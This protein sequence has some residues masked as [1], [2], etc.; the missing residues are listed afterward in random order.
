MARGASQRH[1][2]G[3]AEWSAQAIGVIPVPSIRHWQLTSAL[4]IALSVLL[5]LAVAKV[6]WL[7]A[8]DT[9]ISENL[10][11]LDAGWLHSA[12]VGVSAVFSPTGSVAII[13]LAALGLGLRRRWRALA[14]TLMTIGVG[15]LSSMVVKI[16]ID[17]PRPPF[18]V[19][20]SASFPS[21]HVALTT[22]V[23][24]AVFFLARDIDVRDTVAVG[25]AMLILLVAFSRVIVGA[26][27]LTDTIGSVLLVSGV[28]V[29]MT[30][31]WGLAAGLLE[32]RGAR[33]VRAP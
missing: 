20:H 23:V 8:Q 18:A 31:C 9:A 25:G 11:V 5:G 21:G 10:R 12:M 14:M 15:W 13:A 7:S 17:R 22:A 6:D 24:F 28:V 2:G 16:L 1:L 19:E 3:T 27:Y 32:R 29:G 4:L 33:P 30:G 26:H